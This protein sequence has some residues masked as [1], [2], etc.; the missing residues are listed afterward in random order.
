MPLTGLDIYK[1]LPRTNCGDCGVPTCLAFA[2]KLARKQAALD[3]C[4]HA[5]DEAKSA[6]EGASAPPIQL[7]KIG[8]GDQELEIGN[9][10][11]IF[12]HEETFHH[13]CGIAV[14]I[15][16]E[17]SDEELDKEIEKI[18]AL[19]FERVGQ[20]VGV[21]LIAVEEKSGD[22]QK[23]ADVVKKV[24]EKS[25]QT[26]ILMS[27]DPSIMGAALAVSAD[28]RPL[29][30]AA[31][32]ENFEAM[33]ALAKEHG[34]PLAVC[35]NG[36]DE[37]ADLTPKI[38]DLGVEELVIDAGARKTLEAMDDLT[39]VRRQALN[40]NFR[41]LG[42]PVIAFT[43]HKGHELIPEA[44]TYIAKYAGIVVVDGSEPWQILPLLALR[45][46]VY[47]DP[48]MP[49]QVEDK[50]NPI[51][52]VTPDSPVLMTTNFSLT[53]FTVLGEVEASKIPAYILSINTEGQSVL[54][55]Y[56]SEKLNVE[57]VAKKIKDVD[58]ENVVNHK[59]IVIPGYV[60][61]MSGA[62]EGESGWKVIV[63]PREAT[64][65]SAFLKQY[66]GS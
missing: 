36:I 43:T 58:L 24:V 6:L 45:Q 61:V 7:V 26:P 37:V 9:E 60:A 30:Y 18:S 59:T 3:E 27:S 41:P 16:D 48:R 5:S 42:Y 40:N 57:D 31:N 62:L 11:V 46:N 2:M 66:S 65:I 13:P 22:A 21:E 34:T 44:S 14:R 47:T 33:A 29:I 49:L 12:R 1:L 28:K 17:L 38:K 8:T 39:Q 64:G 35:G 19:W 10:T 52:E 50:L 51:G 32:A 15:T 25:K 53:Y 4:P 54:T 55:A 63:G 20:E 56:A 23:Y